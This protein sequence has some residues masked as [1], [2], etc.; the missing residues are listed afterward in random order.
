MRRVDLRR[1]ERS[2]AWIGVDWVMDVPKTVDALTT[3]GDERDSPMICICVTVTCPHT[4]PVTQ[5]GFSGY[6]LFPRNWN[7]FLFSSTSVL[8]SDHK[9]NGFKWN[10]S[11]APCKS[12]PRGKTR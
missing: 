4:K 1:V 3:A 9:R 7:F 11:S 12:Q 8:D 2:M 6:G 5:S 10:Q